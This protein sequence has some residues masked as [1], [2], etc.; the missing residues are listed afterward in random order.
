MTITESPGVSPGE[1]S[2]T[3]DNLERRR[4]AMIARRIVMCL[5]V[6]VFLILLLVGQAFCVKEGTREIRDL[7]MWGDP[8][9]PLVRHRTCPVP[10]TA[11]GGLPA[12]DGNE[13][14]VFTEVPIPERGL[15]DRAGT[16]AGNR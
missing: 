4:T 12:D 6:G 13:G 8:D 16:G 7:V 3:G 9:Y 14:P 5:V 10:R 15:V 11:S 2:P 1:G